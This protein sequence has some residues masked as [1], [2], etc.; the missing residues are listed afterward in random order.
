MSETAA[1]LLE[2]PCEF[3]L[4]IMGRAGADFVTLILAIVVRHA[5]EV[6]PDALSVRASSG[7]NYVS[8]TVTV[9][10]QSQ[11]QLDD[12]YRELSRHERVV[13]VL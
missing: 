7:G 8:V 3:P 11:V 1:S 6:A 10:A 4:K 9:L 12:L 2:F 5:G 13:M